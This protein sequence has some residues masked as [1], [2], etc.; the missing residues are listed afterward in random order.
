MR[1]PANLIGQR[2]G[3]IKVI[4]RV[5]SDSHGNALWKCECDCGAVREIPTYCLCSGNSRSCGCLRSDLQRLRARRTRRRSR[6]DVR[7]SY[8]TDIL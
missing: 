8:D 4:M 2:F 6:Y 3:R 5:G 1:A 7:D